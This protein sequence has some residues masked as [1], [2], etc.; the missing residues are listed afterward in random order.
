[1][2]RE[3]VDY[4]SVNDY[5][6]FCLKLNTLS[7]WYSLY[8]TTIKLQMVFNFRDSF[9]VGTTQ[10]SG[11]PLRGPALHGHF[12]NSSDDLIWKR[13]VPNPDTSQLNGNKT[14]VTEMCLISIGKKVIKMIILLFFFM[15]YIF[16]NVIKHRCQFPEGLQCVRP[17]STDKSATNTTDQLLLS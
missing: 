14:L 8:L 17:C 6:S 1:M 13:P 11:N 2:G 3:Y 12:E 10:A 7:I 15:K 9:L 5:F 16:I 4:C